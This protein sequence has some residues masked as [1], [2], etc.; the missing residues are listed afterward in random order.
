MPQSD[1]ATLHAIIR[2]ARIYRQMLSVQLM[3][4]GLL[5]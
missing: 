4:C 5:D 3:K 2:I 1:L